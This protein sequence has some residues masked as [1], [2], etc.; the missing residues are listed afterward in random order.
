MSHTRLPSAPCRQDAGGAGAEQVLLRTCDAVRLSAVLLHAGRPLSDRDAPR[1]AEARPIG[2]VLLPGFTG[3]SGR[4]G[5]DRVAQALTAYADVLVVNLRGHGASAGLSTL[6]DREVF[7]VDAAVG[8]MRRRGYSTVVTV[9]WSMG[10]TCAL[11]HAALVGE[12]VHLR[13]VEH[14]ADA[15]VTVSSAG[16]WFYR[17]TAPMR[18]LHWLVQTQLGRRV[19]RR[20]F[21]VRIDSTG[22]AATPL[23]PAEAAARLDVPLLVVHGD[24]DG[25][26]PVDHARAIA[27]AAGSDAELWEV[28]G[29]GHAEEAAGAE[30]LARI[31]EALPELVARGR[32]P[33]AGT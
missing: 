12:Q 24:A 22:W 16:W 5:V 32:A 15:V 33:A 28:P 27:T 21:G 20:V 29:F 23:D 25:Y 7:D 11:R 18:R 30:L 3:C 8:E 6:G 14:P 26:L 4:P 31:G 10:G 17:G 2:V 19:A 9:G 1:R 13:P